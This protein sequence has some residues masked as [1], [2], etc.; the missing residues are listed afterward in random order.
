MDP[1]DVVEVVTRMDL[2]PIPPGRTRLL[3]EVDADGMVIIPLG[4]I[5][6]AASS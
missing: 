6:A 2:L 1:E 3:E 4:E 5:Q